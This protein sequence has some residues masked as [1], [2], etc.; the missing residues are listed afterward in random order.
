[1]APKGYFIQVVKKTLV[2]LVSGKGPGQP[3]DCPLSSSLRLGLSQ[4]TDSALEK[5]HGQ[6]FK[7]LLQSSPLPL[8]FSFNRP[9]F[10]VLY[11]ISLEVIFS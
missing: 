2:G 6:I 1:M 11:F 8:S 4:T 3:Q 10:L 7:R 9:I 5:R